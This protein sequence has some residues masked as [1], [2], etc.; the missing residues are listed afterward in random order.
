MPKITDDEIDCFDVS[1]AQCK[2]AMLAD[3]FA[4][5]S[6]ESLSL[7][8]AGIAGLAMTLRDISDVLVAAEPLVAAR[9]VVAIAAAAERR[10]N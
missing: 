4:G 5:H 7:S 8:D 9:G 10:V 6:E 3:L 1:N 2:V